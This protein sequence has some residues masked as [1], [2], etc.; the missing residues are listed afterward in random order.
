[1]PANAVDIIFNTLKTPTNKHLAP[2]IFRLLD[3]VITFSGQIE[4]AEILSKES[5]AVLWSNAQQ[6]E[7]TK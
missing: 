2:S 7:E 5:F 1:V 4:N 3:E 6:S